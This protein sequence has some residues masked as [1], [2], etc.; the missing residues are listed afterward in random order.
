[1]VRGR[2][3]TCQLRPPTPSQRRVSRATQARRCSLSF[4]RRRS[5]RAFFTCAQCRD[6]CGRSLPCQRALNRRDVSP[7]RR[8]TVV[9]RVSCGL[10]LQASAACLARCRCV[11]ARCL[12]GGDAVLE[13]PSRARSAAM[14]V[15]GPY[16]TKGRCAGERLSPSAHDRCA[17]CQLRPQTSSQRRVSRGAGAW[18]LAVSGDEAQ[19]SSSLCVRAG[20]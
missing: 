11:G 12:S 2:G 10:Q 15:V 7:L 18:A 20:P 4:G 13:L 19:H 16:P 6:G 3:A 5:T 1:M 17:T 8:T 14:A 9:R